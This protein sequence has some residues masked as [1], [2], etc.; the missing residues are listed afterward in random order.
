MEQVTQESNDVTNLREQ[1]M[2]GLLSRRAIL[3]RGTALALSAPAIA[4]LLAACGDD[5]NDD[6]GGNAPTKTSGSGSEG[7]GTTPAGDDGS[8]ASG[9]GSDNGSGKGRGEGDL[10]RLLLWQAPTILNSHFSQGDKDGYAARLVLEPLVNILSD[11]TLQPV[12]AAEV[13]SLE[14]G[15]VAADGLSVTWKLKEGVVWSDGEPFTAED[16]KFTWEF[17]TNQETAATTFALY[18][19]IQSVEVVDEHTVTFTYAEPNPGWYSTF[20]GGYYGVVL[21]KHILADFNGSNARNAD[22][23]LK[24]IGTG[25]YKVTEFRPGD[26]VLY[27]INE[28]YREADKPF[29]KTVELKGGGDATSAARAVLQTGETDYSWNLQV[30]KAILEQL[31]ESAESGVIVATLGNS[32]EQL[33]LNFADPNTEVDGARSEPTTQHPIFSDKRVR[34]ALRLGADRETVATQLYG[35]AGEATANT[36]VSPANFRSPNTTV[37]FDLDGA[38]A[39]LD[40]AGWTLD[41]D[42]RKKDGKQ[43][44]IIYTTTTSP[45]RQ[46]TQEILKQAWESIGVK[47]ELKAIDSSVYFSSD[48]GNPDTVAHFYA[49]V[50]M[51][52]N[53]P[54]SPY[55]LD[56]MAGFKS[57][58]PE[59]DIAQQANQWAGGN[60]NR[61]V[62]EDFNDLWLQAKTEMDPDTQAELFIA[63]NDLII[64]E[65]VRIGLVHRAIPD[66]F[67]KRIKGYT[68][69]SWDVGFYDIANWYAED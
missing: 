55:P 25:P 13:P 40:E 50:T 33:L 69:S 49:D 32:V 62:N 68:P 52:T 61:W 3:K 19:V 29:F 48:A 30:E 44:S 58:D 35:E 41:G 8:P 63:M 37:E 6:D 18:E 34:D 1:V 23:N 15:G 67:S 56:Y 24:P 65:V 60:Y 4:A 31:S 27:E 9:E 20:A 14:N 11:G 7:T 42:T 59:R 12:L 64:N 10:L 54:T 38:A 26:T 43:L 51:F 39:L 2:R 53:G 57:D 16:V 5:N 36:L 66:G 28:S 21:P 47:V 46:K 22:F 17:S 45:I